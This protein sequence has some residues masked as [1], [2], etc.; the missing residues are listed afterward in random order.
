MRVWSPGAACAALKPRT[1]FTAASSTMNISLPFTLKF[2]GLL[3][4]GVLFTLTHARGAEAKDC[5]AEPTQNVNIA[6]GDIFMGP[7]CI[8]TPIGDLDSFRFSGNKDDVYRVAVALNEE[9]Y[10]NNVCFELYD[11][12]PTRVSVACS[13]TGVAT[14]VCQSTQCRLYNS[15]GQLVA[16]IGK[17]QPVP[18]CNA[19]ACT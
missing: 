19:V 12:T 1:A 11:R 3:L 10:P 6:S 13:N 14:C 17:N 5:P 8:I 9:A 18:Q 16:T 2:A 15:S 4:T 7:N